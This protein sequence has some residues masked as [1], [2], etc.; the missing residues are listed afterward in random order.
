LNHSVAQAKV[1]GSTEV[2]IEYS[3]YKTN[4]RE[5]QARARTADEPHQ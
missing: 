2:V 4:V 1:F 5:A 3:D